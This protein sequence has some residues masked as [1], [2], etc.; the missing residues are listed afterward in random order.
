MMITLKLATINDI[1]TIRTLANE[2]WHAHYIDI[3]GKEQVE[4]M[5]NKMY[6]SKSLTQQ[7]E[8]DKHQFYLIEYNH[9]TIGF[10]SVSSS[11]HH[12]YF[13][14]KFYI[15]QTVAAK[16]IGTRVLSELI[17]LL[18]QKT[19]TLT[20]NR[21]NYKSI[22]FYFKNGFVIDHIADFDIENGFVMNDFVMKKT[23]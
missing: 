8:I 1:E 9:T 2:I 22:N 17:Q 19:Y 16:G 10:V 12:D 3:I 11:N 13:I 4:Y 5:L 6:D 14:H 15:Q 7:M 20:V 23:M 18:N 21:Q